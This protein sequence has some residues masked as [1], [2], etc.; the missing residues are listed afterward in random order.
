MPRRPFDNTLYGIISRSRS[1]WVALETLTNRIKTHHPDH[2]RRHIAE[3]VEAG[4]LERWNAP[5][6]PVITLSARTAQAR[7]VEL[8]EC[9]KAERPRWRKVRINP[10]RETVPRYSPYHEIEVGWLANDKVL[11]GP[12]LTRLRA[13]LGKHT[14]RRKRT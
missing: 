4:R 5:N 12:K 14:T 9:G 6:G 2:V 13:G 7:G 1:A 3:L 11:F 8:W 10:R